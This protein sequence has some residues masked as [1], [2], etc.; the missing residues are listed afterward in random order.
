[1]LLAYASVPR[2]LCKP[3]TLKG[4]RHPQVIPSPKASRAYRRTF[5]VLRGRPQITDRYDQLIL[6]Y[7]HLHGL[8]PRLLKSIIAAES[9]FNRSAR[10]PAGAIGLMQLMPHTAQEM[11]VS[12][13]QL[14][15]PEANIRA[16]A[17]YVEHLFQR[18]WRKYNLKGVRYQDA[19][20]WV[21]QRVVAA[22][23]AGP[24]FLYRNRW[25]RQ[26][27]HYVRKVLL[28]YQSDVTDIRRLP[29]N[30]GI[31]TAFHLIRQSTGIYN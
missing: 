22:Y 24:R 21:V 19:P 31:P 6:K 5:R 8:D 27:R 2:D 30:S 20:V 25:H 17:K 18:A 14:T 28:F 1:M 23:N 13:G 11:G 15:D 29:A 3:K 4:T 10:S 26:T 16:G 12:P 7:A 9:E